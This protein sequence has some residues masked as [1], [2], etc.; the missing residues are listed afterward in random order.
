[1]SVEFGGGPPAAPGPGPRNVGGIVAQ[2]FRI[3]GRHVGSM[4]LLVAVFV[5]PLVLAG[6]AAFGPAYLDA[7]MGGTI[8]GLTGSPSSGIVFALSAYLVLYTTG[9]VVVTGAVSESAGRGLVGQS[10]SIGR[11]YAVA[12]RRLPH[13]LGASLVAGALVAL[14]AGLAL[15]LVIPAP[16]FG[17]V[18]LVLFFVLLFVSVY[19]GIR[20]VFAPLIA[21]FQ[22]EGPLSA[23][24]RSWSLVSGAWRRTFGLLLLIG[25]ILGVLQLGIGFLLSSLPVVE[26]IATSLLVLPLSLIGNLLI[27]M[28]LRARK[29]LYRTEDLSGELALLES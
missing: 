29:Q 15:M 20:L 21:L 16:V 22:Q 7:L 8:D 6:V 9:M 26:A 12:I 13:M 27:Y 5:V 24:G 18:P 25:L 17:P 11:A 23:V 19:L 10:I 3:F 2:T 4:L 28:D 1:M 14:P